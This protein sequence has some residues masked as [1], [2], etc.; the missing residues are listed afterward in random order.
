MRCSTCHSARGAGPRHALAWQLSM[1]AAPL[2]PKAGPFPSMRCAATLL[3]C[4][5]I[6]ARD[7]RVG[8]VAALVN[9]GA[10]LEVAG[11]K[12]ATP[13]MVAAAGGHLAVVKTLVKAGARVRGEGA[14]PAWNATVLAALGA[15]S[16]GASHSLPKAAGAQLEA[17]ALASFMSDP[18]PRPVT[19]PLPRPPHTGGAHRQQ[20]L[21]RSAPCC[22]GLAAGPRRE[23][24]SHREGAAA[25]LLRPPGVCLCPTG[26]AGP[27][28][29]AT[30]ALV[31]LL[32]LI[33]LGCSSSAPCRTIVC[34]P[35]FESCRQVTLQ[36]PPP[37]PVAPTRRTTSAGRLRWTWRGERASRR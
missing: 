25:G 2:P 34:H 28:L 37:Y 19:L 29:V 31:A 35:R 26:T 20:G 18:A 3:A 36:P 4:R 10:S 21:Q 13:L 1:P 15:A 14:A 24:H 8:I 16:P 17:L 27:A 22:D 11:A 5:H 23:L 7:G 12:G 33:W 32:F 6:A 9:G 30:W